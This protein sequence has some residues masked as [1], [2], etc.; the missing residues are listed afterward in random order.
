MYKFLLSL[1]LIVFSF[2]VFSTSDDVSKA[3]LTLIK[4]SFS[5]SC[6]IEPPVVE[7]SIVGNNGFISEKWALN[8]CQGAKLYQVSFYPKKHFPKRKSEFV[9]ELVK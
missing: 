2:S 5:E 1:I 8:T 9:V 4:K 6:S 7:N 3:W